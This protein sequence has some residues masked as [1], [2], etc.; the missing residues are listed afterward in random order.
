MPDSFS[1]AWTQTI[2]P[3]QLEYWPTRNRYMKQWLKQPHHL[4]HLIQSN[5]FD[6][7]SFSWD[8]LKKMRKLKR[9]EPVGKIR[10]EGVHLR[11]WEKSISVKGIENHM[12]YIKINSFKK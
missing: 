1:F 12:S 2:P 6:P 5:P 7:N 9:K 3:T 10:Y 4:K 11:H 8:S